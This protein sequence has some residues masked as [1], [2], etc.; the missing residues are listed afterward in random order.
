MGT[1]RC[2]QLSIGSTSNENSNIIDISDLFHAG[3]SDVRETVFWRNYFF[4][5]DEVQRL[6]LTAESRLSRSLGSL[7]PSDSN[8][9]LDDDSSYVCVRAG[10]GSPPTSLN[11]LTE[12]ASV[13]DL[14]LVDKA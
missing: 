11:S 10:V 6:H 7:I 3:R 13:G 4:H 12:T 9:N 2:W 14:V 1:I 8:S 5:C